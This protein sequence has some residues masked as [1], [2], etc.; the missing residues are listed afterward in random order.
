MA[1]AP[2]SP[3]S[4]VQLGWGGRGSS[5]ST[6]GCYSRSPWVLTR[7]GHGSCVAGPVA[8]GAAGVRRMRPPDARETR[9][10]K[11]S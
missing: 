1:T 9:A 3:S 5:S 6:S 11:C 2:D 7:A 10:A 4:V 8:G